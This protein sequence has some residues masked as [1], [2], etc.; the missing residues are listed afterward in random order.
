FPLLDEQVLPGNLQSIPLPT[1]EQDTTHFSGQGGENQTGFILQIPE[2]DA[3]SPNPAYEALPLFEHC[4]DLMPTDVLPLGGTQLL[5][6]PPDLLVI[7][8][9]VVQ[10][11]AIPYQHLRVVVPLDDEAVL[12]HLRTALPVLLVLTASLGL[13]QP[14]GPK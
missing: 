12:M 5:E 2:L 10:G 8:A 1:I 4:F 14:V 13:N 3:R 11:A 7:Q 9:Q 6:F